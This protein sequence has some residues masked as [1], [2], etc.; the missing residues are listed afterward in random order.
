MF[1]VCFHSSLYI[2]FHT[3]S[4]QPHMRVEICC[5]VFVEFLLTIKHQN[6]ETCQS[7]PLESTDSPVQNDQRHAMLRIQET[8]LY[9]GGNKRFNHSSPRIPSPR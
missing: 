5:T 2:G 7:F 8:G 1:N 6:L 4:Q 3:G 9:K